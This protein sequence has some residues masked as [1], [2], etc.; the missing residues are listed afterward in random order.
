[1]LYGWWRGRLLFSDGNKEWLYKVLQYAH[2]SFLG[3]VARFQA[4]V[5][6]GTF[7]LF[8]YK[9][10]REGLETSTAVVI[11]FLSAEVS[12]GGSHRRLP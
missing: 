12:G 2:E 3:M 11:F 10:T 5:R 4:V 7:D 9:K 6:G 1:M 8:W